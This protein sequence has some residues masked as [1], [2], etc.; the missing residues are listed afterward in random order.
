MGV[1]TVAHVS[2]SSEVSSSP[3]TPTAANRSSAHATE[4][5][6]GSDGT[7]ASSQVAPWSVLRPIQES[8]TEARRSSWTARSWSLATSS[9]GA[10]V[11]TSPAVETARVPPASRFETRLHW[12]TPPI[13]TSPSPDKTTSNRE[14]SHAPEVHPLPA[15]SQLVTVG[16]T[17]RSPRAPRATA[18]APDRAIAGNPPPDSDIASCHVAPSSVLTK[19]TAVGSSS[20]GHASKPLA[21]SRLPSAHSVT[22][23]ENRSH[24]NATLRTDAGSPPSC[25]RYRSLP[26]EIKT[27]AP[28]T[29]TSSRASGFSPAYGNAVSGRVPMDSQVTVSPVRHTSSPASTTMP[30]PSAPTARAEPAQGAATGSQATPFPLRSTCPSRPVRA[31]ATN[32]LAP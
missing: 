10:T 9:S 4:C 17:S 6:F 29:S 13:A 16:P 27:V 3:P 14:S 12:P 5:I 25:E 24:P 15:H 22:K 11:H 30:S 32:Q 23:L 19:I 20:G 2:A 8:P 7:V 21:T 28:S 26:R 31:T 18:V 1:N